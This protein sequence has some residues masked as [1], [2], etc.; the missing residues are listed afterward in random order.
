MT[1]EVVLRKIGRLGWAKFE[2]MP[3]YIV[4]KVCR[5]C[6]KNTSFVVTTENSLKSGNRISMPCCKTQQCYDGDAPRRTVID[7]IA[8][9][10]RR[11]R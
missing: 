11:E 3:Q 8:D 7:Q 9:I 5:T 6:G 2:P 1:D 10:E 4:D